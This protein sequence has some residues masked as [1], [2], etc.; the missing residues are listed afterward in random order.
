MRLRDTYNHDRGFTLI[1]VMIGLGILFIIFGLGLFLSMDFYKTFSF[2]SDNHIAISTLHKAR[3]QA[4]SNINQKEHGV[5][6]DNAGHT[7]TIFEGP[8]YIAGAATNET[9]SVNSNLTIS[10]ATADVLFEQLTGDSTMQVITISDGIKTLNI[11]IN[12]EGAII[13]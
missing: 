13:Y 1:E 10:P 12:D 9:V 2:K 7:M 4:L 11:T 6:F 8:T 3:T 5:H